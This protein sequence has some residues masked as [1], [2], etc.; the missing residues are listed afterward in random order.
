MC[1]QRRNG[2]TTGEGNIVHAIALKETAAFCR[3]IDRTVCTKAFF[4]LS[5]SVVRDDTKHSPVAPLICQQLWKDKKANEVSLHRTGKNT[6][7]SKVPVEYSYGWIGTSC[8]T[9]T[10][11]ELQEDIVASEDGEV[12]SATYGDNACRVRAGRCIL[13]HQTILWKNT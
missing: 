7:T 9:T 6:W 12:I 10:N 13:R 3:T 5:L 1:E 4:R 2:R 8:Y 11:Y